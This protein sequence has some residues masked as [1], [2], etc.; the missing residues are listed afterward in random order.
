[1][2]ESEPPVQDPEDTERAGGNTKGPELREHSQ[3]GDA[4]FRDGS[5]EWWWKPWRWGWCVP[6]PVAP[7]PPQPYLSRALCV[8]QLLGG[9]R[10]KDGG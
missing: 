8:A 6:G 3:G 2:V 10:L 7:G 9:A 5:T 4:D 1:M